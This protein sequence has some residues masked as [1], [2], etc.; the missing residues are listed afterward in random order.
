M[1]ESGLKNLKDLKPGM[2]V[3]KDI[4]VDN[5]VLVSE[6]AEITE[7]I[8]KKLKEV[9]FENNLSIKDVKIDDI[10]DDYMSD[11][12]EE[13]EKN[14]EELK[15]VK[16]TIKNFS[17]NMQNMFKEMKYTGKA[18]INDV[19]EFSKKIT[20]ELN[21]PSNIIK[22]IVLEGSGEDRIFKH[23]V[24]VAALSLLLGR[25]LGFDETKNNLLMYSAILHDFGKTKITP[26][27]LNKKSEITE[28]DFKEI[29]KHPIMGYDLV[30]KVPYLN[31]SVL[32]GILMHH[33]RSDGS[34]YP[35]GLKGNQIDD[36]SKIIAIADVFDAVN[37]NRI[38]KGKEEPF[39]ALE[40]IKNESMEKLDYNF[41]RTFIEHIVNY[42]IGEKALLSNGEICKIVYID[43]NNLSTPLV[44]CG[45]TFIDLKKHKE[46]KIKSLL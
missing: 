4:I 20:N 31:T 23:S 19:R 22:N 8:I 14:E 2:I 21:S 40:I 39:E 29:K 28:Q 32:Y 27:I 33:E 15:Q 6:G 43:T 3:S 18:D 44:A 34:G 35:L 42:Y 26:E 12:S 13:D 37:S 41:S 10:N 36:F 7:S 38:Y 9:Y 24:N 17:N 16:K 46:L 11:N 1:D 25:W 45:D 30:K 5:S